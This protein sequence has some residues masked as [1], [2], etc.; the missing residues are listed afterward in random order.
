MVSKQHI[1]WWLLNVELYSIFS[2]FLINSSTNASSD[3]YAWYFIPFVIQI[4]SSFSFVLEAQVS[5]LSLLS[6]M[7]SAYLS[8]CCRLI[9]LLFFFFFSSFF[10][11]FLERNKSRFLSYSSTVLKYNETKYW[12]HIIKNGILF[13]CILC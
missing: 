9:C 12:L 5:I 10:L 1:F 11:F 8:L 13:K 7:S 4:I 3:T 6:S 2:E